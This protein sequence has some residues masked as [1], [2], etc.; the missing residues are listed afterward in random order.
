[1]GIGETD[2]TAIYIY[3]HSRPFYDNPTVELRRDGKTTT[4]ITM[5]VSSTH[6]EALEAA[7]NLARSHTAG[8]TAPPAI[9]DFWYTLPT[10]KL[11]TDG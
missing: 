6:A 11:A 3:R 9:M 5:P 1:M 4:C 7:E 2:M 10:G 8:H